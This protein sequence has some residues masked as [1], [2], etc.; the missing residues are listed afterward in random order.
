[1]GDKSENSINAQITYIECVSCC[2]NFNP[3]DSDLLGVFR[4]QV[5]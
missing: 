1:M 4:L 3:L 2:Y 5:G